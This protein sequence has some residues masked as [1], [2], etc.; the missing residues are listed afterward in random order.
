L[1]V[2]ESDVEFTNASDSVKTVYRSKA[3]TNVRKLVTE[4]YL[5]INRTSQDVSISVE[6]ASL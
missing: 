3:V 2:A 4:G 6:K 1:T 5:K